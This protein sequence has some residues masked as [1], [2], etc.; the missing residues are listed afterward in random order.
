MLM[1]Q[2]GFRQVT[3][4]SNRDYYNIIKSFGN[5]TGVPVLLNTSLNGN[6]IPILR[7]KRMQRT[8]QRFKPRYDDCEWNHL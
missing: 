2:L 7:Q 1:V 3:E 8:F 4:Q 5:L 6:G